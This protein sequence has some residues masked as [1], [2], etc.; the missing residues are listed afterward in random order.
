MFKGQKHVCH[1]LA[2][3]PKFNIKIPAALEGTTLMSLTLHLGHMIIGSQQY[4]AISKM[5]T[6]LIDHTQEIENTFL[7]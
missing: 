3:L 2:A 6:A 5:P 4:S 7:T 1:K